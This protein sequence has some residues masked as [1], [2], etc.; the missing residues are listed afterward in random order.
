MKLFASHSSFH[1]RVESLD[2]RHKIRIHIH[3]HSATFSSATIQRFLVVPPSCMFLLLL[4]H[5]PGKAGNAIEGKFI[6]TKKSRGLNKEEKWGKRNRILR[7][8]APLTNEPGEVRRIHSPF[9]CYSSAP[10]LSIH[11]F[12]RYFM[13][14]FPTFL[15]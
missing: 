1:F 7:G 10:G 12:P 5:A 9:G 3:L 11:I 2:L 4:R 13:I 8:F 6:E 14:C 15:R